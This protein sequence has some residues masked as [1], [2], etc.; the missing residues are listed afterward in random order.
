MWNMKC[1]VKP[2]IIVA[3]GIVTKSL[4]ISG[5]NTGTTFDKFY[6]LPP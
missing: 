6:K 3:A 5:N 2:I 4:K 1:F